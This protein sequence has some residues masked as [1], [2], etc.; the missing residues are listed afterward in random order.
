M[1]TL[2]ALLLFGLVILANGCKKHLSDEG[3]VVPRDVPV[4]EAPKKPKEEPPPPAPV[5]D[6]LGRAYFALDSA[7]LDENAKAALRRD[8]DLLRAHPDARVETQ[9]HCDE[10]GTTDYNIAL[11]ERRASAAKKFLVAQGIA[12]SRLTTISYGEEKPASYGH[13]EGAWA[14]NRRAELRVVSG[15]DAGL[16]GS[17]P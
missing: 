6:A 10:R 4:E 14:S 1:R 8:A 7:A 5:P 11:G 9:G 2:D 3:P 16:V 12:A 15:G 13:D 17:V